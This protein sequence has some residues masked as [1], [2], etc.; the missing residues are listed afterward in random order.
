MEWEWLSEMICSRN[1]IIIIIIIILYL[2][3]LYLIQNKPHKLK[4]FLFFLKRREGSNS[5]E[6]SGVREFIHHRLLLS[7]MTENIIGSPAV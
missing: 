5:I 1:I 6:Q 4:Y 3:P 2:F 7:H